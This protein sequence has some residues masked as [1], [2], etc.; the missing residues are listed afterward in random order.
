MM[1]SLEE[2]AL[3]MARLIR[4]SASRMVALIDNMLDLARGRLGGGLNLC[5]DASEP[6]EPVLR[7]VIAELRASYPERAVETEFMLASPSIATRSGL[8]SF[9]PISCH[10][11]PRISQFWSVRK[12]LRVFSSSQ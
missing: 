11:V 8:L 12:F 1:T 9:S 2:R 3:P 6:L 7:E 10:T 4:E 5:C